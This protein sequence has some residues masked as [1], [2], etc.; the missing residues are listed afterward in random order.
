M[1]LVDTLE[2]LVPVSQNNAD[3]APQY[4]PNNNYQPNSNPP[5]NSNPNYGYA[6]P[7][8]AMY[9][10]SGVNGSGIQKN[11]AVKVNNRSQ[12]SGGVNIKSIGGNSGNQGSQSVVGDVKLGNIG[13]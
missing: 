3:Y 9:N 1:G 11:G 2:N 7:P 13:F 5:A 12:K 10:S 8:Y 6:P 4:P